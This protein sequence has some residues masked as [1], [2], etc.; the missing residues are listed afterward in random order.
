MP[1]SISVNTFLNNRM[2]ASDKE[3]ERSIFQE[4]NGVRGTEGEK[5]MFPLNKDS[6]PK[7]SLH[8]SLQ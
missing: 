1:H 4:V 8:P 5:G 6:F 2:G 3:R 7:P